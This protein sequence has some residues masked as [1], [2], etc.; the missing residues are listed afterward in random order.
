MAV[1]RQEFTKTTQYKNI[2]KT[3]NTTKL[4]LIP[5]SFDDKYIFS[6]SGDRLDNLAYEFYGDPRY[7]IILAIANNLGKGTLIVPP[8]LQLRIP[9]DS[10][11]TKFRDMFKQVEEER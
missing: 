11:I 2:G 3:Y 1:D 10:V 7:W 9:A 4:P 5:K 6:R 8:N